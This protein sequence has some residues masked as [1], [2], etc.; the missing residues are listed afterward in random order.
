MGQF[1][2][3]IREHLAYEPETGIVRWIKRTTVRSK[4]RPGMVAGGR[5]V[6]GYWRIGIAGRQYRRARI[7]WCLMTGYF[8]RGA[9]LTVDHA[10]QIPDDDRWDNLRLATRS[11]QQCN[12]PK[13]SCNSGYKGIHWDKA[14][15][16]WYASVGLHGKRAWG[17]RFDLLE[18]AVAARRKAVERIHGKFACHEGKPRK[19]A[20]RTQPA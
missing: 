15:K 20:D 19:R 16:R 2:D 13:E 8:P 3:W 11:Q 12:R 17:Q 14:R 10:N 6:Q 18:E 7:A 1:E 4:G 9:D 5:D